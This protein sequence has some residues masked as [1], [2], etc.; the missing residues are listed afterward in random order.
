MRR[1]IWY[2]FVIP[3]FIANFNCISGMLKKEM[4]LTP[5]EYRLLIH[6]NPK[7]GDFSVYKSIAKSGLELTYYQ[8]IEK[9]ENGEVIV[10]KGHSEASGLLSA[11]KEI[12]F[13]Y[14]TDVNGY[15]KEA[16]ITDLNDNVQTRLKTASPE[17]TD[18]EMSGKTYNYK[19]SDYEYLDGLFRLKNDPENKE[20]RVRFNTLYKY[21][22]SGIGKIETAQVKLYFTHPGSFFQA[23]RIYTFTVTEAGLPGFSASP[24]RYI[25]NIVDT[26]I[27]ENESPS[28]TT[29]RYS[30]MMTTKLIR[31]GNGKIEQ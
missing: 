16:F 11:F 2:V 6:D 21:K 31:T 18:F 30:G 20:Y 26:D 5:S 13:T 15:T 28:G 12:L 19:Y 8:Q 4:K 25:L 1:E 14:K 24:A 9:A 27:I 10:K 7:A 22:K 3:A 23:D 17:G 29:L